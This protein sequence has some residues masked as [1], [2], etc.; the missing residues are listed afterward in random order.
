MATDAPL[1]D[2]NDDNDDDNDDDDDDDEL[3]GADDDDDDAASGT[4]RMVPGRIGRTR[5][6]RMR[7][8]MGWVIG[9]APDSEGTGLLRGSCLATGWWQPLC[10]AYKK[11]CFGSL[12]GPAPAGGGS[13]KVSYSQECCVRA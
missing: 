3:L 9:D 6:T 1:S 13:S 11:G 5:Q 12:P 2:D 7:A 8:P 10:K 4:T